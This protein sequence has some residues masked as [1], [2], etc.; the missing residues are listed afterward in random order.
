GPGGLAARTASDASDLAMPEPCASTTI[1]P[2]INYAMKPKLE[3]LH[4]IFLSFCATR[5]C[6]IRS[7]AAQAVPVSMA[8]ATSHGSTMTR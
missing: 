6:R 1:E 4:V 7:S 3:L 5:F 8:L 2:K